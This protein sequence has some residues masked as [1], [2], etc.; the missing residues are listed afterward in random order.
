MP[1]PPKTWVEVSRAALRHNARQFRRA[2]GPHTALMAVVKSNAYGH[3]IAPTVRALRA[4][5]SW[6]GVDALPEALEVLKEAPRS[7]VLILGTTLPAWMSTAVRRGIRLSVSSPETARDVPRGAVVHVEVETGLTRQGVGERDLPTT[8]RLLKKRGARVEGMFTH[9][10]NIEDTTD[11][12]YARG[13]L[14]RFHRSLQ[15]AEGLLGAPVQFPHTACSAAALL[16]PETHFALARVGISLYGHW[17][18]KETLVSARAAKCTADLRP[19]LVWKTTVAQV[20]SVKA[21]TPI[22]YGLTERMRRS[23]KIAVLPI[24]YWDGYD[25]GLSS[26]GEVLIRGR[27]AKI[28]GRICMNMC[29]VDVSGISGVRAGDEA[30]LLGRQG[31]GEA[32]PAEEI[33]AKLGTINYEVLTRINPTL[34]RLLV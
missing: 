27:R 11:H 20:K 12:G 34:P 30:V 25:R 33:A 16:F 5:A 10:A 28:M 21:G 13:Q 31:R 32:I 9:Y 6:F 14:A 23:G 26:I 8:L 7:K 15:M 18:S 22:S 2:L 1:L 3:G 24:G 19:A 4:Q 29:M 17:P